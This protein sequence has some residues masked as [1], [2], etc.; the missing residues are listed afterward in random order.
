MN[1]DIITNPE[2]L[3]RWKDHQTKSQR[4]SHEASR[5]FKKITK[6]H[7]KQLARLA[8]QLVNKDKQYFTYQ[9]YRGLLSKEPNIK[10]PPVF[11][12]AELK[13]HG[14]IKRVSPASR[15][16]ELNGGLP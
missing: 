3:Q 14:V 2:E 15:K 10:V 6:R 8:E 13:N 16:W 1:T 12:M 9:E 11:A 4:T 5:G 7:I